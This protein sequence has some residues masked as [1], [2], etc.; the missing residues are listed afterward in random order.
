VQ[1]AALREN[2]RG[3]TVVTPYRLW[4]EQVDL[5]AHSLTGKVIPRQVLENAVPWLLEED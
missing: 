2:L 1:V 4:L 5:Q 3:C